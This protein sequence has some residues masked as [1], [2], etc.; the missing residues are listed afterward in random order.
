MSDQS[1][2]AHIPP[3]DPDRQLTVVGPDDPDLQHLGVV[4]DTYTI[5]VTGQQTGNRY[6]MIDMLIPPDGGPPPHRHD[7]EEQFHVL[8]GQISLTF[9]GEEVTAHAGQTVNIPARAPHSFTNATDQPARL[10][11]LVSPP[12][13]EQYFAA[14]G[15][16]LPSRTSPAPTL[17]DEQL[18]Q[19]L[20]DAAPVADR[21]RIENLPP[22]G[23]DGQ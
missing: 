19:K 12:G 18:Q 14:F 17:S 22:D 3:D 2:T 21:F 13:I 23:G 16:E 7:F 11:C 9:R 5:L 10:L 6:A 15:D 1:P 20:E 8:E 4:G